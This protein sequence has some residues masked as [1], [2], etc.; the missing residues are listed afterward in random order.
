M[1]K[2]RAIAVTVYPIGSMVWIIKNNKLLEL[3]I[4]NITIKSMGLKNHPYMY[5]LEDLDGISAYYA[6]DVF[7]SRESLV[8]SL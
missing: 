2:L 3:K 7:P 8:E 6:H 1:N 4:V 5:S